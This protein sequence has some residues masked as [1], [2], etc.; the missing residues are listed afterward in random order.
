MIEFIRL[1]PALAVWH[2]YDSKIKAELFSTALA[3]SGEVTIIDPIALPVESRQEIEL[4]GRVSAIVI[5]NA[6]HLRN[7]AA[8]AHSYSAPIFAPAELK[9]DLPHS[10]ALTDTSCVDDLQVIRMDGAAAGEFALY[11]PQDGGTL[12]IGDALIN[13]DPHGFTLLPAKY[14]CNQKKMICSL[15]QLLDFQFQRILFAHGNPVTT[16]AHDRLAAL[17]HEKV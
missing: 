3:S 11:H 9:Q 1:S 4:H 10:H 12:I 7:A 14:C 13:F 8:F 17:M 5:T 15:R 6:N 2:T 16:R